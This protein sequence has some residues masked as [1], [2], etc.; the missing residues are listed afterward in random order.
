MFRLWIQARC[1]QRR[2]RRGGKHDVEEQDK[3]GDVASF[4]MGLFCNFGPDTARREE[5]ESDVV[6]TDGEAYLDKVVA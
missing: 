6:E 4:T 3:D 2:R 5:E 1:I